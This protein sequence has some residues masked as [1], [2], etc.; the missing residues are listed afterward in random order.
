MH[1][2]FHIFHSFHPNRPFF[3]PAN[4]A[5]RRFVE[6][7]KSKQNVP[8]SIFLLDKVIA[9]QYLQLSYFIFSAKKGL[10]FISVYTIIHSFAKQRLFQ[11]T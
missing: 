7:D 5:N 6:T 1:Q 10:Q 3:H 9:A 2:L 4:I 8:K 11:P